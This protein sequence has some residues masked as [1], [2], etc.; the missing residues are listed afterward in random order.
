MFRSRDHV[1]TTPLITCSTYIDL[2]NLPLLFVSISSTHPPN[3]SSIIHPFTILILSFLRHGTSFWVSIIL[4]DY[5]S[6]PDSQPIQLFLHSHALS[7]FS[8]HTIKLKTFIANWRGVTLL[9]CESL[10]TLTQR[11]NNTTPNDL[12]KWVLLQPGLR[13]AGLWQ[14][15]ITKIAYLLM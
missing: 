9:M 7:T 13:R 1:S 11:K 14:I 2:V 10:E 4:R 3:F 15:W 6:I 12:L 8:F 5:S